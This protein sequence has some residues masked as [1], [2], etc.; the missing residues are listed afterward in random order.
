VRVRLAAHVAEVVSVSGPA[1][2][3]A[4][5]G[6]IAIKYMLDAPLAAEVVAAGTPALPLHLRLSA[7][8]PLASLTFTPAGATTS[9]VPL[10]LPTS[11][12][13]PAASGTPASAVVDVAIT[14]PPRP[15]ALAGNPALDVGTLAYRYSSGWAPP[16]LRAAATMRPAYGPPAADAAGVAGGR[17][18]HRANDV[19]VKL[20]LH[21]SISAPLTGVQLLVQLPPLP[22]G[23]ADSSGG[24]GEDVMA[25]PAGA[26]VYNEATAMTKPSGA[27]SAPR[28]QLGSRQ[29]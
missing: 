13:S 22:P 5:E 4:V 16:V 19:V 8:G 9:P 1:G 27:W 6:T 14:L 21:T 20:A 7:P 23:G 24:G 10:P 15:P 26:P 2:G 3:G 25:S 12:P 11:T 28:S 18:Q 29:S 17:Q